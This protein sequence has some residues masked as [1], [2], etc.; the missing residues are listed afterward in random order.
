MKD[1]RSQLAASFNVA[2]P[3]P[4]AAPE[5]PASGISDLLAPDAWEAD[6]WGQRLRE[7]LGSLSD[8][9][10]LNP[11][12]PSRVA[13]QVT[14]RVLKKLK[15]AGRMR[16]R[17]ELTK[18]RADFLGRRERAAWAAVKAEWSSRGL[19]QKVY[20]RLKQTKGIDPVGVLGKLQSAG[21]DGLAEV[22]GD[23]LFAA[24]TAR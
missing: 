2:A 18:L 7:V 24:L 23:R 19:S 14:D 16:D 8:A 22:G 3:A 12:S 13:S 6:P 20:R 21:D 10:R 5:A 17:G 4:E 15:R 11:D 9:P 1:L